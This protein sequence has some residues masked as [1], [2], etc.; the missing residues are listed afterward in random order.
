MVLFSRR[1]RR[2]FSSSKRD[3]TSIGSEPFPFRTMYS[4]CEGLELVDIKRVVF[5]HGSDLLALLQLLKMIK[6]SV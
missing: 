5:R 3:L 1:R 4:V 6:K 2:P